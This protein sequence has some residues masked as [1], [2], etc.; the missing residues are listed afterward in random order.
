M[1]FA[2]RVQ[3]QTTVTGTQAWYDISFRGQVLNC[4]TGRIDSN[5]ASDAAHERYQFGNIYQL[6]RRR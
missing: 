1:N 4:S 6:T 5:E 2:T 3:Y